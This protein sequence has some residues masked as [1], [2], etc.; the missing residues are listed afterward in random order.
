MQVQQSCPA[1]TLSPGGIF[2]GFYFLFLFFYKCC[3]YFLTANCF[4]FYVLCH[5]VLLPLTMSIVYLFVSVLLLYQSVIKIDVPNNGSLYICIIHRHLLVVTSHGHC[6]IH[7]VYPSRYRLEA[8][9]H[10]NYVTSYIVFWHLTVAVSSESFG[11]RRIS[12]W[13][14]SLAEN[15]APMRQDWI[16]FHFHNSKYPWRSAC[17]VDLNQPCHFILNGRKVN[18]CR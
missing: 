13:R 11:R 2:W 16:L 18:V 8:L 17:L 4:I 3:I 1:I 5:D 9:C 6:C 14:M 7:A 10:Y 12:S 15:I